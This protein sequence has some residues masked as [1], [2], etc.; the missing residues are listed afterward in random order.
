M[1]NDV[2]AKAPAFVP[3]ALPAGKAAGPKIE[4]RIKDVVVV[5]SEES[6]VA[7]VALLVDALSCRTPTC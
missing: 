4:I 1:S 7:Y 2:R 3:I 6:D 5:I